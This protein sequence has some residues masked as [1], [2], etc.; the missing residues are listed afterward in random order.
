VRHGDARWLGGTE[1]LDALERVGRMPPLP[2]VRGAAGQRARREAE[3]AQ[4][5]AVG[6]TV[7]VA[8]ALVHVQLAL[9]GARGV[10]RD[11]ERVWVVEH[12]S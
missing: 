8:V 7:A 11:H 6:I 4:L 1:D 5:V 9:G 3:A 2:R 10:G 12:L